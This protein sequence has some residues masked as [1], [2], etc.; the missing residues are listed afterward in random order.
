MGGQPLRMRPEAPASARERHD[1]AAWVR[2]CEP[3]ARRYLR[4]LGCPDDLADD[5]LQEAFLAALHKRAHRLPDAAGRTWLRSAI[6]N[7]WRHQARAR[8]RR[9][10]VLTLDQVDLVWDEVAGDDDGAGYLNALR[11]CLA[12]L[13][14]RERTAVTLRY[15][16]GL[17]IESLAPTSTCRSK[18]PRPCCA[19]CGRGCGPA[20]RDAP[21]RRSHDERS[22][23][24]VSIPGS[25]PGVR[26]VARRRVGRTLRRVAAHPLRARRGRRS[27][28]RGAAGARGTAR[29]RTARVG[30]PLG[31]R[32]RR[33][34]GGGRAH[35]RVLCL[36]GTTGGRGDPTGPRTLGRGARRERRRPGRA[37]G[38][39]TVHRPRTRRGPERMGDHPL[40]A[41][42]APRVARPRRDLAVCRARAVR[43][44]KR[45]ARLAR[46]ALPR[47]A[48]SGRGSTSDPN[49]T[50][51][52]R[53]A[54]APSC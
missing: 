32:G 41:A 40:C 2:A 9:P 22:Q 12:G 47:T 38:A 13:D 45:P 20:S 19:A 25:I 37:S 17:P 51:N 29:V 42:E 34:L 53:P 15:G 8:S 6:R 7:L 43:G 35:D 24:S 4:F 1:E 50:S 39:R 52:F 31:R 27:R 26:T 33:S 54:K 48:S 5:L 10:T 23:T 18:A 3:G 30:L 16:E 49:H 46:R 14:A 44:S 28:Q 21:T 11:L 36:A